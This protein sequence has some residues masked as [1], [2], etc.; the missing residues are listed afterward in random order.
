VYDADAKI[1][2]ITD[3]FVQQFFSMT[4]T[5]ECTMTPERNDGKK[6]KGE[7]SGG[8]EEFGK[9]ETRTVRPKRNISRSED[10]PDRKLIRQ[11]IKETQ[12]KKAEQV[13]IGRAKFSKDRKDPLEVGDI[14]TISTSYVKKAPI[15]YLPVMVTSIIEKNQTIKYCMACKE[16]HLQGNYGRNELMHH[17]KYTSKILRI[18]PNT[19]NFKK[20]LTIQ[21][22][23]KSF[24]NV[25]SCN[26]K[27]DCSY[28][29]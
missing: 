9:H 26:C 16:G 5:E 24:F 20:T 29:S 14:G 6:K 28:T 17:R 4:A 1:K 8:A 21:D 10:T 11:E 22:A 27:G 25:T 19:P 7:Q 13:N 23:C 2:E 3:K 15:K 12:I 18:D